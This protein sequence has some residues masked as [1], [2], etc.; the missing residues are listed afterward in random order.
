[1]SAALTKFAAE[2]PKSVSA[3]L[4]PHLESVEAIRK[5]YSI[6]EDSGLALEEDDRLKNGVKAAAENAAMEEEDAN[7]LTAPSHLNVAA[8]NIMV[9]KATGS[10]S[11]L[12]RHD[13]EGRGPLPEPG[14]GKLR[15]FLST[16]GTASPLGSSESV[17]MMSPGSVD[18]NEEEEAWAAVSRTFKPIA[19]TLR[20]GEDAA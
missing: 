8:P 19:D 7:L 10:V 15:P 1:M 6:A 5:E 11:P 2:D 16:L 12:P 17:M 4:K 14:T 3:Q 9:T 20:T 13:S 18:I